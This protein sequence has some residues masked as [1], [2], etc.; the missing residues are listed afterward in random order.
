MFGKSKEKVEK[1]LEITGMMCNHCENHVKKALEGLKDTEVLEVS[2]E[3]G[4][5]RVLVS[6]KTEDEKLTLVVQEAG[7]EVTAIR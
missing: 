4:I 1:T 2:H 5:A 7:Y 6:P 3:K